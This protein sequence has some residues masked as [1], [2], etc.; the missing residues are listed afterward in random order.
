MRAEELGDRTKAL[1][2][3]ALWFI[4]VCFDETLMRG[5]YMVRFANNILE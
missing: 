4:S 1:N 3:L 2:I 5:N